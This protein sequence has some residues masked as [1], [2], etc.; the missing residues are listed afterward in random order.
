MDLLNALSLAKAASLFPRSKVSAV[1]LASDA[2]GNAVFITG[3]A[4]GGIYQVSKADPLDGPSKMPAFGVIIFKATTTT[5]RVQ[6]SGEMIGVVSSLT[7]G[8]VVFVSAAGT[9]A[10]SIATP[11]AGQLAY[12]QSMGLVLSSDIVLLRPDFQ[13]IKRRG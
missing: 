13:I 1:C 6:V 9:L 8:K 3:P 2:V 12:I 10:H 5:C 4:I 7:P 11:G